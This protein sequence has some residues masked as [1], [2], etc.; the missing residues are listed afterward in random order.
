MAWAEGRQ[1]GPGGD[2]SLPLR[3]ID[4]RLAAKHRSSLSFGLDYSPAS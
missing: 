4:P 2:R 3:R 1:I